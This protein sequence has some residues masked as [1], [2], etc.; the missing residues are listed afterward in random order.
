MFEPGSAGDTLFLS[1]IYSLHFNQHDFNNIFR[2]SGS[3]GCLNLGQL[4][5]LYS[6]LQYTRYILTS[7]IS[8]LSLEFPARMDVWTWVSWRHLIL[9]FQ[10]TRYL[11][12]IQHY[13]NLIFRISGSDGCLNLGQLETLD[14]H[15]QFTCYVLTSIILILSLEFPARMDVWTWVSWRHFCLTDS[16]P[17]CSSSSSIRVRSAKSRC[18][19]YYLDG[20]FSFVNLNHAH[21]KVLKSQLRKHGSTSTPHIWK[22][23]S[24]LVAHLSSI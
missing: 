15:L 22:V 23:S 7:M 1:T 8:I 18:K 3:D 21:K 17:V 16:W 14:S 2:I 20:G 11:R 12:F 6:Y 13:F 19:V 24:H 5:T 4:E 9:I 10:F